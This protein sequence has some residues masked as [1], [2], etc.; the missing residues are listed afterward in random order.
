MPPAFSRSPCRASISAWLS[1]MPVLGECSAAAQCSAGSMARALGTFKPAQVVDAI[2]FGLACNGLELAALRLIRCHDELAA[3]LMGNAAFTAVGVETLPAFDA[4]TGFQRT[5]GI[6]DAGMDDLAVCASW[7][8]CQ[9]L[10]PPPAPMT[11]LPCNASA[12]ATASPTTPAPTT[13]QSTCS[14]ILSA[15][16]PSSSRLSDGIRHECATDQL[17]ALEFPGPENHAPS[18]NEKALLNRFQEGLIGG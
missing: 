5:F 18:G 10:Q 8:P 4:Q 13:T 12:L 15:L 16:S 6:V 3:A 17:D 2:G 1:M 7:C 14:L 9:W 11:S